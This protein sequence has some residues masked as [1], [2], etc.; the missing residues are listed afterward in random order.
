MHEIGR[1][2]RGPPPQVDA[3]IEQIHSIVGHTL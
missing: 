2:E 1:G 3:N